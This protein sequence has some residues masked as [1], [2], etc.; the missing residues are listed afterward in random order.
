MSPIGFIEL[1]TILV[2]MSG[3][4]VSQNPNAPSPDEV[5]KY[6]PAK[7]DLMVHV[8]LQ[9]VLPGN[10]KVLTTMANH[11][12]LKKQP[13]L[14]RQVQEELGQLEQGL[15]LVKGFTGIDLINDVHSA[16]AWLAMT[17]AGPPEGIL[18]V[19]GNFPA[20]L[21][22]RLAQPAGTSVTKVAGVS[23]IASPDGKA[24]VA[25]IDRTI[26]AGTPRW[27]R[28]RLAKKW[29]APR[30][31]AGSLNARASA[32][33]ATKPF[34]AFVSAPSPLAQKRIVR[35]LSDAGDA[36]NA[37]VD[38]LTGHQQA[39]FAIAHDGVTWVWQARDAAGLQH[40]AMAS[41]GL[42]ELFRA[43]HLA[44]RG[45]ARVLIA[46]LHSYAGKDPDIDAL[47]RQEDKLIEFAVQVS[48]DGNFRADVRK[49]AKSRT[50]TVDAHGK[51]LS[52]VLPVGGLLPLIAAGAYFTLQSEATELL[53]PP[54]VRP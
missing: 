51:K 15:L 22:D 39:G 6:A 24:M 37:G 12:L 13:D 18:V 32:F 27:V 34:I 14:R 52:D 1:I 33:L 43:S 50:V 29:R 3:F 46:S 31:A 11:E 47:L 30:V 41:E 20:D 16:T 2:T 8:D 54:P 48:G 44:T 5:M 35:E 49:D 38:L 26:V 17:K 10:Y 28:E 9:A 25:V 42:I 4:G 45:L 19:R 23:T 21:I 40:A 53:P 36:K 7:A